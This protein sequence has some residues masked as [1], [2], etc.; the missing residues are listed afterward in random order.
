LK[1][2]DEDF[3]ENVFLGLGSNVGAR[4]N[5]LAQAVAAIQAHNSIRLIRTSSIYESEPY[6]VH[7]QPNFLNMVVEIATNLAPIV[8]LE[9]VKTIENQLGR[10]PTYHWGPRE[11]DIDILCYDR[12]RM[13]TTV[14]S[15]PHPQLA[16]R[17]FVL[18]PFAEIAPQFVLPGVSQ[19]IEQLLTI[20]PDDG[21]VRLLSKFVA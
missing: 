4:H 13:E 12:V 16:R 1:L 9:Q 8:L 21:W 15:I 14:L 18:L 3:T 19:N 7:K 5:Y 11:I 20:C 10:K 6:G 17:R 2:C